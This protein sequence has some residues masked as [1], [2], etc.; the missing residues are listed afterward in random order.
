M[1][2]AYAHITLVNLCKEPANLDRLQGFPDKARSCIN[3]YFR[4]CEL[5]AV[6]PDYPYLA[7]GIGSKNA[8]KWADIMHYARTSDVIRSGAELLS[9]MTGVAQGKGTAW[10][11]GYAAHV[12]TDV[13]IHPI[14]ELKVGTYAG[15]EKE[16]RICE[17]NQD[18]YIYPKLNMGGI[19]LSEHLTNGIARCHD[20]GSKKKLD[21]DIKAL[22][23]SMLKKTHASEFKKNSPKFDKWHSG[24][25]QG[26]DQVAEEGGKLI[27]LARHVALDL[28]VIYPE[29]ANATYTKNLKTPT[30]PMDYDAIFARAIENVSLTWNT[31]AR[32]IFN[33]RPEML[34]SMPNWNLDTGRDEADH[35]TYWS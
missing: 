2:A 3:K 1:P 30:G 11:M 9:G 32:S 29:T 8:K 18:V 14:V 23:A 35:L 10:L 17:M 19:G 33:K 5:G 20:T 31:I 16:H 24:F 28:G 22:W 4:F 27:P 6:S 7:M 12:V 25:I 26:V 21:S 34:A 13:S 15:H